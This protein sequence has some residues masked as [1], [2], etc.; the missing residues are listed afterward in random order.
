LCRLCPYDLNAR[1][2]L[3]ALHSVFAAAYFSVSRDISSSDLPLGS[4]TRNVSRNPRK[5][6]P[7][8]SSSELRT[9]MPGAYPC[10]VLAGSWLCARYRNPKDPMMAPTLPDAAEM[11]WHVARSRAGRFPQAR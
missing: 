5:M 4:G 9:P 8:N 1:R 11:P 10:I 6:H 2:L 3:N 7:A